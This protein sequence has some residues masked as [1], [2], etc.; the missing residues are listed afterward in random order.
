MSARP[1]P[2][3]CVSVHWCG[4]FE[5]G[6]FIWSEW[7]QFWLISLN[8]VLPKNWQKAQKAQPKLVDCPNQ[9]FSAF[10]SNNQTWKC[11][12]CDVNKYKSTNLVEYEGFSGVGS[13]TEVSMTGIVSR[14]PPPNPPPK[15][16]T[17]RPPLPRATAAALSSFAFFFISSLASLSWVC[18]MNMCGKICNFQ[19]SETVWKQ[20]HL[21]NIKVTWCVYDKDHECTMDK[22]YKW[23][24]PPNYQVKLQIKP[25]KNSEAPIGFEPMTFMILVWCST[26]WAMKPR[27]KQVRCEFNLYLFLR[28]GSH[29]KFQLHFT[30]H[31]ISYTLIKPPYMWFV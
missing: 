22:E 11:T 13:T 10:Q 29:P 14:E 31:G 18:A 7:Q 5:N 23:K 3:P 12:H 1:T 2:Q 25:R 21:D 19:Y 27:W 8:G 9:Q 24:W 26:N 16:P 4:V 30:F 15:P 6:T 20:Y 17:D 28:K